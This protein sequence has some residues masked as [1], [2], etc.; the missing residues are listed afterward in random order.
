MKEIDLLPEWYKSSKRRQVS[1]RT[2]YIGVCVLVIIM[3]M[4]NVLAIYSVSISE[5]VL[6]K[7]QGKRSYV[8]NVFDKTA[9]IKQEVERMRTKAKT[10]EQV[11]S[12]INISDVL[13]EISFLLDE[14][15]VLSRFDIE[16]ETFVK[17]RKNQAKVSVVRAAQ[18]KVVA[19]TSVYYGIVKF[20]INLHGIALNAA[21]VAQLI[22]KLEDS[23]YFF[24]V[25]PSF[26]RNREIR[27]NGVGNETG[28]KVSEFEIS[29]YLANYRLNES[30]M[31]KESEVKS[32]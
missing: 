17:D 28:Y 26:S 5:S 6:S 19:Q 9:Q 18:P 21:V 11:D 29:C 32:Y 23:P 20:K 27:K 4:W 8:E 2:Q 3:L 10:L 30:A 12:G 14:D 13:A 22:C 1:Y 7:L 15:I 25:I 31:A 16:A 24:Q